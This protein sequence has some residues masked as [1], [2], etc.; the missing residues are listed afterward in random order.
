MVEFNCF[1]AIPSFSLQ[2]STQP[3]LRKGEASVF[4]SVLNPYEDSVLIPEW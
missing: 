4:E 3:F 2:Q 1:R